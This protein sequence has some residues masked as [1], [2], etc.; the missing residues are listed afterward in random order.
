[1]VAFSDNAQPTLSNIVINKH[2]IIEFSILTNNSFFSLDFVFVSDRRWKMSHFA[3][4][5]FYFH[6]TKKREKRWTFS[7][8]IVVVLFSDFYICIYTSVWKFWKLNCKPFKNIFKMVFSALFGQR[9]TLPPRNW[10]LKIYLT[11]N[12]YYSSLNAA[13]FWHLLSKNLTISIVAMT[14]WMQCWACSL[15]RR[16]IKPKWNSL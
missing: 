9:T 2:I 6:S 1:M 11:S 10:I 15:F 13:F 3:R 16:K 12:D 14:P 4:L 8:M 5:S 7:I